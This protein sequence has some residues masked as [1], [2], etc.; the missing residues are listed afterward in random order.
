M[1]Q[2]MSER[3]ICKR[4][5]WLLNLLIPIIHHTIHLEVVS[6]MPLTSCYL[7]YI[8]MHATCM[9]VLDACAW[10][11]CVFQENASKT[12]TNFCRIY[13]EVFRFCRTHLALS[14][15]SSFVGHILPFFGIFISDISSCGHISICR[16]SLA[17]TRGD[18]E[19]VS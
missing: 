19:C 6:H 17:G 15:T 9:H 10:E 3:A 14:D 16:T 4:L 13:P 1:L 18:W 7:I 5:E 12:Q 8:Y 11:I 2:A